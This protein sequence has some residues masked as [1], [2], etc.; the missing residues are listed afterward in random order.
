MDIAPSDPI[1]ILWGCEGS[2]FPAEYYEQDC[3]SV[4][5]VDQGKCYKPIEL[6]VV[7]CHWLGSAG[8][9]RCMKLSELLRFCQSGTNGRVVDNL[10]V[11]GAHIESFGR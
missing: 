5:H 7:W 10:I 4:R 2:L 1:D 11:V 3:H 8:G 6:I 9:G